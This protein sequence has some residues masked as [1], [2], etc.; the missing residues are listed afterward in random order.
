MRELCVLDDN[1]DMIVKG[2]NCVDRCVIGEKMVETDR[3]V[4]IDENKIYIYSI[5][6]RSVGKINSIFYP[7]I[8]HYWDKNEIG[9]MSIIEQCCVE[10]SE[11]CVYVVGCNKLRLDGVERVIN[12]YEKMDIERDRLCVF[13]GNV[14]KRPYIL[15]KIEKYEDGY[16]YLREEDMKKIGDIVDGDIK[17]KIHVDGGFQYGG[18]IIG[19]KWETINF[20][21]K[22]YGTNNE[23]N[24]FWKGSQYCRIGFYVNIGQLDD[25]VFVYRNLYISNPIE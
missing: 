6:C 19:D 7:M 18:K 8:Y 1:G 5:E 23:K 16:I 11:C 15:I 14:P 20:K 22:G 2:S 3:Y 4:K 10:E 25:A 9:K 21:I 17:V 12:L 13:F 24:K